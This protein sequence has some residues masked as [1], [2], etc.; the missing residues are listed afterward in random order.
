MLKTDRADMGDQWISLL[1]FPVWHHWLKI[2]SVFQFKRPIEGRTLAYLAGVTRAHA[3]TVTLKT[4]RVCGFAAHRQ[5][6][7][8]LCV[9][10][11][12]CSCFG[13]Q[14]L[15]LRRHFIRLVSFLFF[16]DQLTEA[17]FFLIVSER[18]SPCSSVCPGTSYIGPGDLNSQR[19]TCLC[20]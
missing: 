10:Y 3:L 14:H 2:L 1:L 18:V 5:M 9:S 15:A 20:L 12:M 4:G 16:Q 13:T 8:L 6:T 17:L 11:F 7:E 19:S